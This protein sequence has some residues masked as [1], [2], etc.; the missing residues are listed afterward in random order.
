M[1]NTPI[2]DVAVALAFTYLLIAIII[3]SINEW[4][5]SLTK[6]RS[7]D[8]KDT[9]EKLLFDDGWKTIAEKI[10]KSPFIA[11][12][13]KE[14][15]KSPSYIP[16][17]NFALALIDIIMPNEGETNTVTLKKAI[18]ENG[19]ITGD[20]KRVLL[21]LIDDAG[22]NLE[23]FKKNLEQ[24]YTDAM[25][26]ASG[27]Y[28]KKIQTVLL[29]LAAAS[30]IIIN[31]DTIHIVKT[32]WNNPAAA[33][34]SADL[35]AANI[36]MIEMTDTNYTILVSD[37]SDYNKMVTEKAKSLLDETLIPIGWDKGNYPDIS[38][39]HDPLAWL[40]KLLGWF[41][42]AMAASLGAPFWFDMVN[43]FINLRGT[44]KKPNN[45]KKE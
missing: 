9:I 21:T 11:S 30:T 29:I 14:K 26:R 6:R 4:I 19:L 24:F 35:V 28:K 18:S 27:W 40:V 25:D 1:L 2:L 43:K 17:R 7:T 44:G 41:I 15:D 31:V 8:L 38:F 45:E 13:K 33:K 22:Y 10:W 20:T 12:L 36:K 37:T 32:L 3:S 42:T 16:S 34:L 39:I 23:K 5:Q